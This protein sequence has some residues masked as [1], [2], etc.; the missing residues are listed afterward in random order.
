MTTSVV[1][2]FAGLLLLCFSTRPSLVVAVA[3]AADVAVV[4]LV[5]YVYFSLSAFSGVAR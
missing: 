2:L 3:A 1:V 4:V 5:G